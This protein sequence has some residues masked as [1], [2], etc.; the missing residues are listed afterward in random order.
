MS[1]TASRLSA[2][3]EVPH[4]GS[5]RIRQIFDSVICLAIAVTL[6]RTFEVE[7]YIIS[8]GSMAPSLLGYHKRVTCPM[9]EFGFAYGVAVDEVSM[10][11]PPS[12]SDGD[13]AGQ[14]MRDDVHTH[15]SCPNC[16]LHSIN[17][18]GIPRNEGDQLLVQKNAYMFRQPRRWEVVV[19]RNPN[20]PTEAYVKRVIGRSG[21][22]IQMI[23]G[24][25]FAD[26]TIQRKSL[27]Q[28]RAIRI[29]VYD[30]D[31]QPKED[32][33]WQPRWIAGEGWRRSD[34]GFQIAASSPQIDEESRPSWISYRHWIRSG[35]T[36]TTTVS[37]DD[38]PLEV[39]LPTSLFVPLQYDPDAKI[40]RC[41]GVLNSD[42]VER[43]VEQTSDEAFQAAL[44][45]LEAESHVAPIGDVYGY[46]R[47]GGNTVHQPVRDLMLSA[48]IKVAG[49]EGQLLIQMRDGCHF[50]EVVF[51][52]GS[53]EIRLFVDGNE[54]AVRIA[55]LPP[56][57]LIRPAQVEISTFDRQL[58]LTVNGELVFAPWRSRKPLPQKI[59]LRRPVRLGVWELDAEVDSLKLYRDVYYTRGLARFGVDEPYLLAEGEY[60]VLGD[61]SPISLD[62]RSWLHPAVREQMFLGKPF[63]VHLPS[64][65][66]KIR[67]GQYT[68][69]IRIPDFSRIRYI[70]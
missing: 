39:E 56:E 64:K 4:A 24:D 33:S 35:G 5:S 62:S 68:G 60:F 36:H 8:T 46:N 59:E 34:N 50:Y 1:I 15:V 14:A 31:F 16:N 55:A 58:M 61:N 23:A 70:R 40:L 25:V 13:L 26:G 29:P 27:S 21:E 67:V 18:S 20:K 48:R 44:R 11:S 3:S 37:L 47:D 65:P 57:V 2:D 9:C 38:W 42:V 66:G 17:I 30:F 12:R 53:R 10:P 6:F 28:Q 19:F 45:K 49:G 54:S 43:L 52:C 63:L 32:S 7:G 22:R 41:S 69:Y 51:D